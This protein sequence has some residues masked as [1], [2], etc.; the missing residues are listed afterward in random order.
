MVNK[1][2]TLLFRVVLC[3]PRCQRRSSP[4]RLPKSEGSEA[5]AVGRAL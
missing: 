3:L 4:R 2:F 1:L 5:G